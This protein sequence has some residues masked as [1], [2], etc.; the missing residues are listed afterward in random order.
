MTDFVI[1]VHDLKKNF[2]TRR[3]VE[4]LTLQ[5]GLGEICGFLGANGSGRPPRSA[6]CAAFSSPMAGA[7]PASDAT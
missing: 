3:V 6:C 4:G 7:A 5:V 2:G 1:D